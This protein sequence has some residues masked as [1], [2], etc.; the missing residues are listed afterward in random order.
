MVGDRDPE[1]R[2]RV[3]LCHSSG[4]KPS[5]RQLYARLAA[6]GC[7]PWLDEENILPGQDWDHEIRGAIRRA[8][9]TIVCLSRG[10]INKEGYLQREIKHAL[11]VFEEKREG[12]IF[13]I[14]AKL[15]ECELPSA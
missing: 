5:V 15:E 1:R 12:S 10:S 11:D 2:L 8:D 3:F 6:D 14:P 13:I 4:D 7:E 9:A